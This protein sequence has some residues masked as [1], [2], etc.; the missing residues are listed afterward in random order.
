MRLILIRHGES[1]H[2][3]RGVIAGVKGCTGLTERG[4]RQAQEFAENI[5]HT[6]EFND[7]GVLLCSPVLR[8]RQTAEV[9]LSGL[10]AESMEEDYGLCEVHPGE[11]DGLSW[12]DYRARY[13][14]FDL[15]TSPDRPFS[16]GGESWSEF[17]L[18]VRSTL[19]RLA[20][21]YAGQ[22]VV[23]VTHA[24]FIVA[25]FL[26]LFDIPRPGTGARLDPEYLSITEWSVEEGTW[27]LVQFNRNV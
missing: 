11:A 12:V 27:R 25:S 16:P 14:T 15:I 10:P 2:G 3:V 21:Q 18:R 26:V 6:G 9:L 1:Q 19:D 24:G 13:G 20:A 23:A 7:C 4:V 22:T 17:L 8:A 5:A